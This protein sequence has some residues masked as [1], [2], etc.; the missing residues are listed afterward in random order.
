MMK[1]SFTFRNQI[2][3]RQCACR[4][5]Y[6]LV[7]IFDRPMIINWIG[8]DWNYAAEQLG[9]SVLLLLMMQK[10]ETTDYRGERGI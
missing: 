2:Q 1:S 6:S 10:Q 9:Y 3:S 5:R 8:G 7:Y 4:C